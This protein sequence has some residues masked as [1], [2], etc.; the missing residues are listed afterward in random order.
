MTATPLKEIHTMSGAEFGEYSGWTMPADFGNTVEEYRAVRTKAGITDLSHRGKLRM[1]GRDCAKFLQGMVSNDVEN[2][3]L[4][5]WVYCTMLTVKG[6]MITDM[7]VLKKAD[8]LLIDLEPGMNTKI[9]ELL[10]KY[11]LSYKAD[12]DDVTQELALLSING[13]SSVQIVEKAFGEQAGG[14][15]GLAENGF[16][17]TRLDD[18]AVTLARTNRV[19]ELGFDLYVPA[20]SAPGVWEVVCSAGK[21]HGLVPVGLEALDV[22]RIEVGIPLFGVDMTEDTIPL[23]AGLD[24]AISYEKGCYVGQEV[25]ARIHYRGH[26]NRHL[27][28]FEVDGEELPPAGTKLVSGEKEIGRITSAAYSPALDGVIALGYIRRELREPGT[29]VMLSEG[30]G[31]RAAKV[32]D[33]PFINNT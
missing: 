26:V 17:Q 1:S 20:E 15:G 23:E 27:V 28:G 18:A 4:G 21:E 24:R 19:G 2:L 33:I 3:P 31:D 16:V 9:K 22:L 10:E 30:S 7:R 12:I 32:A 5:Q 8:S 6:R 25:V 14:P 29:V 13:P 11:R